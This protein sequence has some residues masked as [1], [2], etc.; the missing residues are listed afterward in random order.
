MKDKSEAFS[1]LDEMNIN[2]LIAWIVIG[3]DFKDRFRTM[4]S[5]FIYEIIGKETIQKNNYHHLL[6]AESIIM[7]N[8]LPDVIINK[9]QQSSS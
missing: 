4:R 6:R 9:Y 2:H 8:E 5:S 7:I 1:N 3:G